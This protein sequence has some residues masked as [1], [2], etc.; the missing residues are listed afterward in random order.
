MPKRKFPRRLKAVRLA[1]AVNKIEGVPVTAN[2]RQLSSLW[3]N[4]EITGEAMVAA[5]L[6]THSRPQTVSSNERPVSV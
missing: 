5:L 1:D 3:A 6:A 2:A 4:G